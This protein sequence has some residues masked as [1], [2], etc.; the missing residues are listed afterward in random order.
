MENGSTFFT[1]DLKT[2]KVPK[3]IENETRICL[4]LAEHNISIQQRD[5]R[6][7]IHNYTLGTPC[8]CR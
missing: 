7:T 3:L 2:P 1:K 8:L 4:S 5:S 6:F